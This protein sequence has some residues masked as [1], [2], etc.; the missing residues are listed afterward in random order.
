[1]EITC[2]AFNVSEH[3]IVEAGMKL[4]GQVAKFSCTKG[5]YLVGNN[6][7]TCLANGRWTGKNPVCKRK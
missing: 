5:R 2:P 3:L 6:T 7:R 1:M 4:V